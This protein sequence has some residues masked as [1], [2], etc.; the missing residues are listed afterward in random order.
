MEWSQPEVQ[1]EIVAPRAG[2]AGVTVDDKWYIVGGGDN[3]SGM[4]WSLSS[5]LC[6][7]C[8]LFY[9]LDYNLWNIMLQV[10]KKL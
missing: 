3:R 4:K 6:M 9:L 1:G 7:W 10:L 8:I 5:T 2:H